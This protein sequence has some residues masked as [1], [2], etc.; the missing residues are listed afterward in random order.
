MNFKGIEPEVQTMRTNSTLIE[1]SLEKIGALALDQDLIGM[2]FHRQQ[3]IMYTEKEAKSQVSLEVSTHLTKI[4][5]LSIETRAFSMCQDRT[6]LAREEAIT[7]TTSTKISRG[8]LGLIAHT[9][10]REAGDLV[11]ESPCRITLD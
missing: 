5:I 1:C 3:E 8:I 7:T 9:D 11:K 4:S 10:T 6:L 2:K